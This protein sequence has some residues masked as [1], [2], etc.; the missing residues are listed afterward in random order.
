MNN[1][2][3]QHRD[4][5]T[6]GVSLFGTQESFPFAEIYLGNGVVIDALRGFIGQHRSDGRKSRSF[7][8]QA[9]FA[10]PPKVVAEFIRRVPGTLVLDNHTMDSNEAASLVESSKDVQWFFWLR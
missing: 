6:P 3:E 5:P 4:D 2:L 8:G 1:A 10:F 7:E 9:V